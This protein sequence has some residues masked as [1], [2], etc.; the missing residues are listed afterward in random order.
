LIGEYTL[1]SGGRNA[2]LERA[3]Q[4]AQRAQV[5]ERA[6]AES[7]LTL[8]VS[9]A[10]YRAIAAQRLE[11]AA[12]EAMTSARAHPATSAAPVAAGVSPRLDSLRARGDLEQR[13][14]ALV[15]ASEAVRLS[16]VE[17]ETAIGASLDSSR[18]LAEPPAPTSD[19]TDASAAVERALH[20]RP[21][22][23][24]YDE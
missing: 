4:A 6:G 20:D 22:L 21:E 9:Q 19:A 1:Y 18:T 8:R 24:R 2:A 7:D 12:E 3:A 15:R 23:A 5:H 14:T 11:A 10:F 17:L 13:A 16:R